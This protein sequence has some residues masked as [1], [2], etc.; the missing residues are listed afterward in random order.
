M[1]LE[2]PG[3][4]CAFLITVYFFW[5]YS[6][7]YYY[8]SLEKCLFGLLS[9]FWLGCV[10]MC[11]WKGTFL[12]GASKSPEYA[13]KEAGCWVETEVTGVAET[14]GNKA[15]WTP[16]SCSLSSH[17]P[18]SNP[19]WE[20]E[21]RSQGKSGQTPGWFHAKGTKGCGGSS[22]SRKRKMAS[23]DWKAEVCGFSRNESQ[24]LR[25]RNLAFCT[26]EEHL[27]FFLS[28]GNGSTSQLRDGER[29]IT[30]Y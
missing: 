15:F 7:K 18:V 23:W 8:S 5:L 3:E 14:K 29:N 20:Q 26:F 25:Q 30:L 1:M 28:K 13:H 10:Y 19:C 9:I 27:I 12:N 6:L 16:T 22:G 11:V 24:W 17:P 2:M 21:K 4:V